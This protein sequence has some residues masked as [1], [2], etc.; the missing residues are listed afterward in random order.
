MR[1][2]SFSGRCIIHF[3]HDIPITCAQIFHI[4][5][6]LVFLDS[7][8]VFFGSWSKIHLCRS[9]Y[10]QLL[11]QRA[12]AKANGL[13]SF[14]PNSLASRRLLSLISLQKLNNHTIFNFL[15]VRKLVCLT[16]LLLSLISTPIRELISLTICL[17]LSWDVSGTPVISKL[18]L[19]KYCCVLSSEHSIRQPP[20][21]YRSFLPT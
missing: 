14:Q 5:H 20:H 21:V 17:G 10:F 12:I 4:V 8:K 7:S 16:G 13:C 19:L 18:S 9:C 3:Q 15:R 2:E 1:H 11:F 6:P